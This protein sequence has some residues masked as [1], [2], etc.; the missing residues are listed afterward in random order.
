MG[1]RKVKHTAE[2]RKLVGN[3]LAETT[4]AVIII[5]TI[6][7]AYHSLVVLICDTNVPFGGKKKQSPCR[8]LSSTHGPWCV[9]RSTSNASPQQSKWG[10][11]TGV[12][13]GR[14]PHPLASLN[15]VHYRSLRFLP[16]C[17][18]AYTFIQS[19]CWS[20]YTSVALVV[21][22]GG[23]ELLTSTNLNFAMI[24]LLTYFNFVVLYLDHY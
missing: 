7:Y 18:Q 8:R 13:G 5:Q 22:T 17:C 6:C 4:A 14:K 15:L 16:E 11:R 9:Y 20:S 10:S 24:R 23:R 19:M 21:C 12:H 2:Y 1:A 3:R